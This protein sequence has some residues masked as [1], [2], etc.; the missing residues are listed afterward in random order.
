MTVTS[1]LAR[2][3]YTGNGSTT[4]FST[5]FAFLAN[6]DVKVIL[7][8]NGTE[9]VQVENTH[10]TLTGSTHANETPAP[11]TVTM[12][13][14]PVAGSLLVIMRDVLFVQ[15]LDG[16]TLST[17]DAGDQE[18]AY[19]R[20][21]HAMAQLKEGMNRALRSTDGSPDPVPGSWVPI[22]AL[23]AD[24]PNRNVL[25]VT[26]WLNGPAE[27]DPPVSG[28]YVGPLGYVATPAEATNV[29]GQQGPQGSK[30]DPG[31]TGSTGPAGPQGS[32]GPQGPPG[33]TGP[34]GPMGPA[35]PQ[36]PQGLPGSPGSGTGDMIAANNL[37]ELTDKPLALQRIGGVAKTGGADGIMTGDL[38][39]SKDTPV[40]YLDRTATG[41]AQ[42]VGRK[43]GLNRWSSIW[44]DGATE[45]G[46]N[47]GSRFVLNA[48][49]DAG[50]L[51]GTAFSIDRATL[52]MTLGGDVTVSKAAPAI[53]LNKT[54]DTQDALIWATKAGLKRWAI[55]L[56][57]AAPESG[58]NTGSTFDL[59]YWDD[60]GTVM[61]TALH[62]TRDTGL[63]TVKGDPTANLGVATKQY[64]DGKVARSG[65][66]MGGSLNFT[67]PSHWAFT[68]GIGAGSYYS[69]SGTVDAFFMGTD[70]TTDQFRL[71]AS[72]L[73][74]NVFVVNRAT[75]AFVF[76]VD[77]TIKKA[78]PVLSLDTV[79]D[80][81]G[82]IIYLRNGSPRWQLTCQAGAEGGGASG[83]TGNDY[84]ICRFNNSGAFIDVALNIARAD[85]KV[86]GTSIATSVEYLNNTSGKILTTDKVWAAAGMAVITD[87]A[88]VAPNFD[89]GINHTW[90]LGAAGRTLNNPTGTIKPGMTG[91]IYLTNNGSATIT[92]WGTA[93]KFPGG[94]KPTLTAVNGAVDAIAYTVRDANFIACTFLADLK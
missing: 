56:A 36:G 49:S 87:A 28:M 32:V 17:M 10:Y 24:G 61:Q 26:G 91:M 63:L 33:S 18:E 41:G 82:N 71:Y 12:V 74:G 55:D 42:L 8:I 86:S 37:S 77:A 9:T 78:T 11:G 47:V 29:K 53:T 70:A 64:A 75:G 39:I 52:A 57:N 45:T 51:I 67:A 5:G 15:D 23:E 93:Y 6:H 58:G 34:A 19:D 48:F 94:T 1:D 80:T 20:I 31:P 46:G 89:G 40:I 3:E 72:G 60:G 44:G 85:A 79:G 35:G 92:T 2:V 50:T 65:D 43:G 22:L 54:A 66:T 62:G 4:V 68:A 83:S 90:S 69:T 25:K 30:G 73:A 16:T 27:A 59:L 13:T 84:L 21:W 76:Q 14:A 81:Q 7:N 38:T 88:A